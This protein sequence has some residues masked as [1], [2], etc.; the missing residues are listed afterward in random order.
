M[1]KRQLDLDQ[2]SDK[3]FKLDFINL[4]DR[5]NPDFKYGSL[6]RDGVSCGVCHHIVPRE[7]PS[8]EPPLKDFLENSITGKFTVGPPNR[9]YG[10]FRN[11]TISTWPMKNGL[12]IRPEHNEYVKRSRLCGSCHTIRLPVLDSPIGGTFSIEQATY[13]EWLNSAYQNEFAPI[14]STA[15][16]CQDCHMPGSIHNKD[17]D[18]DPLK[19]RIAVIED[20]TYP[21]VYSRVPDEQ[22]RVRKRNKGFARHTLLGLNAFL[23]E[24]FSQF[25]D[26]L[27]V[28][29]N[30]YMSASTSGL[31]NAISNYIQQA[32]S[33][34]AK[35]EVCATRRDRNIDATVTVTNLTGH[36]LP[37]GVGFRR[38]FIEFLVLQKTGDQEQVVWSSGRTNGLG[39]I[40]DGNGRILPSEFFTT[41]PGPTGGH[42]AFQPH[43][44]TI[45]S[46]DQVQIY[47]ELVRNAESKFTTNFVQ[48]DKVAKDNRLLPLGWTSSGPDP[49]LSGEFLE[50]TFPE[51]N[52]RLDPEYTNGSGTDQLTYRVN[53]PTGIDPSKCYVKATLFYQSTPPYYLA[54]RFQAAP[55]APA[56]QRL[57]YLGSHADFTRTELAN[58]KLALVSASARVQ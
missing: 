2:P 32:Q 7:S 4:T 12:G 26:I 44:E 41:V 43:Y 31:P 8:Y 30:D 3:D 46:Q 16:T 40:V 23:L 19:E 38:A 47:E 25:N 10:P 29:T 42:Q 51:G 57:Y 35:I 14:T 22:I 27:G 48:R 55:S 36:R 1:G 52:A 58:W 54:M 5:S 13:L 39:V 37:S 15:K 20:S 28:R 17:V 49:S 21:A 11:Q 33:Q 45:D 34:S 9:L 18:V 6:A 53:L 56:T 50:S 24:M